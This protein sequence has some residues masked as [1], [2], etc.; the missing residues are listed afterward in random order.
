MSE[1]VCVLVVT[2]FKCVFC[3]SNVGL[4]LVVVV[5]CHCCLVYYTFG[6]TESG[7]VH[8]EGMFCFVGSYSFFLCYGFGVLCVC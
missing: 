3:Q 5:S 2:Y 8:L 4:F 6:H 1:A 7:I